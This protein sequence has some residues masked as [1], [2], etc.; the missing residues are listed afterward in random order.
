MNKNG[1]IIPENTITKP[2]SAELRP[3]QQDTDSLP[4]YE[5][6]DQILY[7][8]IELNKAPDEIVAKG[9]DEQV[10]NKVIRMVNRNEYKR[11]QTAPILRV[12]SKAF[13][14]GRKMPL[15]ARY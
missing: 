14:V 10:V 11:F 15:V 8:F 13:G 7:D 9:F 5:D 2:P 6:L 3:N 12:S 4:E 1:E